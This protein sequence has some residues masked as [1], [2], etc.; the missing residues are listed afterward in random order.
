[1]EASMFIFNLRNVN[2]SKI[3]DLNITVVLT[4]HSIET[5]SNDMKSKS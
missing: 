3:K 5:K 4:G 1:M 2:L